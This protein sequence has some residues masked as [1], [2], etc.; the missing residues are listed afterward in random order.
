MLSTTYAVTMSPFVHVG[1]LKKLVHLVNVSHRIS[2]HLTV[3]RKL[4][5]FVIPTEC[6]DGYRADEMVHYV[7]IALDPY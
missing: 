6:F 5:T 7:G 4:Y 1:Y 2:V 3:G